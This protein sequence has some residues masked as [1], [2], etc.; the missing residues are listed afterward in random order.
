MESRAH[1][2]EGGACPVTRKIAQVAL[3]MGIGAA[4]VGVPAQAQQPEPG[5]PISLDQFG[6]LESSSTNRFNTGSTN[7]F[8][9]NLGTNGRSCAT[10]HV[11]A[12]AWTFTPLHAQRWPTMIRYSPRSMA[13]IARRW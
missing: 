7:G 11:E 9:A 3:L 6:V 2:C 8:F 12:N 10:C 4:S 1:S 5:L 13:R